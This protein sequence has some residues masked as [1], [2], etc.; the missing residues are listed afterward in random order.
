MVLGLE[1]YGGMI[2]P[3]LL[4]PLSGALPKSFGFG[5]GWGGVAFGGGAEIGGSGEKF[6]LKQ[7]LK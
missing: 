7:A 2:K 1:R 6:L 4:P 5:E 3:H